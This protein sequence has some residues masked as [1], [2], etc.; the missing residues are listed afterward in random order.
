MSWFLTFSNIILN[1]TTQFSAPPPPLWCW[2]PGLASALSLNYRSNP[3]FTLLEAQ[4]GVFTKPSN[5]LAVTLFP[6]SSSLLLEYL[7]FLDISCCWNRTVCGL[8]CLATLTQHNA[9]R[10]ILVAVSIHFSF[11][12]LS[13][14][15][16]NG[17]FHILR[18]SLIIWW[19]FGLFPLFGYCE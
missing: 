16:L 1:H 11:L 9:L 5:Q 10:F 13:N 6:S 19:T 12:F 7:P 18:S 2:C 8:F 4:F 15:L 17:Q 14:V 3:K